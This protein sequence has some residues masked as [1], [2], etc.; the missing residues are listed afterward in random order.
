MAEAEKLKQCFW[1][2]HAEENKSKCM[3]TKMSS[4]CDK[5]LEKKEAQ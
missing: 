3:P 1:Q 2:R 4:N 5:I